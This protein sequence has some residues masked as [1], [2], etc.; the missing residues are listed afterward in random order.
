MPCYILETIALL[1]K[2]PCSYEHPFI[3]ALTTLLH[4]TLLIETRLPHLPSLLPGQSH[5][6]HCTKNGDLAL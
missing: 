3:Y 4:T 1:Q 6:S 5:S 2:T